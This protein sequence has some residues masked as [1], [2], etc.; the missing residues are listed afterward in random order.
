MLF[1]AFDAEAGTCEVGCWLEP[2][3]TG[4]GLVTRAARTII[5]WAVRERGIHRVEWLVS[6]GNGP[7]IRVAQRLGMTRE[8]VLRENYPHRGKRQDTEIWSVLAPDWRR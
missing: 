6:T 4:R 5:D 1:P 7:S 3:G 2:A 8:G